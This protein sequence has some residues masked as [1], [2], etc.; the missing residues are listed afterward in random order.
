MPPCPILLP[1]SYREN[2]VPPVQVLVVRPHPTWISMLFVILGGV[3][4]VPSLIGAG[5]LIQSGKLGDGLTILV[6]LLIGVP[7]GLAGLF[8]AFT[9]V[10]FTAGPDAVSIE[11]FRGGKRTRTESIPRMELV[12]VAL[13]DSPS[14]GSGSIYRV[15]VGTRMGDIPLT[16][17][18]SSGEAHHRRNVQAIHEF[19]GLRIR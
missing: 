6:F 18:A 2:A 1:V 13:D 8:M 5:S 16:T 19:L 9:T 7:L 15:V 11:W 14:S 17:G 4:A 12:D 10:K 3:F